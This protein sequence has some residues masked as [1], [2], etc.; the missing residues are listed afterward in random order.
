MFPKPCCRFACYLASTALYA[1]LCLPSLSAKMM[2]PAPLLQARGK[3]D[4]KFY[5]VHPSEAPLTMPEEPHLATDARV[6]EREDFDSHLKDKWQQIEVSNSTW[7]CLS[8]QVSD[9]H[10]GHHPPQTML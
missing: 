2:G 6:H 7:Q 3:W 5:Q 4:G 10:W 1:C 8:V 9:A